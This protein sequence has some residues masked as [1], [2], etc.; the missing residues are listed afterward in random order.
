MVFLPFFVFFYN[1]TVLFISRK[2]TF[3]PQLT[4]V[5]HIY[6][7]EFFTTHPILVRKKHIFERYVKNIIQ[8][9]G[10]SLSDSFKV[11]LP[12]RNSLCINRNG[13]LYL[14]FT[15]KNYTE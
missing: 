6:F 12:C 5:V 15:T 4:T 11:L 1:K 9:I 14:E 8:G 13:N 7:L 2:F 3:S 10:C